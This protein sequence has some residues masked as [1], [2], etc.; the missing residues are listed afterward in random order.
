MPQLNIKISIEA[1]AAAKEGSDAAGML[2]RKWVERAIL[3]Y[4]RGNPQPPHN[5]QPESKRANERTVV[6][7]ED[8]A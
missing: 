5:H 1:H 6:P 4:A 2:L 3:E 7:W 8:P